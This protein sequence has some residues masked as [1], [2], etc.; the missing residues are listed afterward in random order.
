MDG[1]QL[2]ARFSIATNRLQYCGPADA[3]PVLYR[4]ITEC[5]DLVAARAALT[6]FE[7]LLPYLDAIASKHGLDPFDHEVVEAYWIGN[8]L[9]DAFGRSDFRAI[10]GALARRGLPRPVAR[11]L[12]EHLPD[13]AIPHHLFHVSF[14]GVGAVTG[15]VPTTLANMESC[16][17][18]VGEVVALDDGRLRVRRPT[19][20]YSDGRLRLDAPRELDVPYDPKVLSGLETGDAVAIH[21]NCAALRLSPDQ[22]AQAAVYT[23]RSLEAANQALPRLGGLG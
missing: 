10:L 6:R 8:R 14:V 3:E 1:V 2:G 21:W 12:E 20:Q 22:V 16:R 23:S 5:R 11:R 9:L 15:H 19:L 13:H 4:A 17:P 7:A 18:A